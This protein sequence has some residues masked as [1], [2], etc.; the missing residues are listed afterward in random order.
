M[1][2][3]NPGIEI[4]D[5]DVIDSVEPVATLGGYEQD[6]ID[7]GND[8]D[9]DEDLDEED[10]KPKSKTKGKNNK[11]SKKSKKSGKKKEAKPALKKDSH[12]DAVLGLSWNAQFR[13]VL[14][15]AS[16]DH[17]VRVWD[18]TTQTTSNGGA[19][20]VWNSVYP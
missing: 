7:G 9:D 3:Y 1:C 11:K 14:A 4:W 5:L 18:I 2:R 16:A 15:S 6:A 8:S 20:Q 17:T 13:N 10:G 19:A 12:T